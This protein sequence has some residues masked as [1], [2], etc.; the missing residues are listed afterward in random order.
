MFKYFVKFLQ[1]SLRFISFKWWRDKNWRVIFLVSVGFC[2][3][4]IGAQG[5]N[6]SKVSNVV[7]AVVGLVLMFIGVTYWLYCRS[8]AKR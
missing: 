7:N 3:F 5:F 1:L 8:E 4:G 6:E 2:L